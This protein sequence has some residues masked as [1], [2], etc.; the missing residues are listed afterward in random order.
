MIENVVFAMHR[1]SRLTTA[2]YAV[3]RRPPEVRPARDF[4][5]ADQAT[6]HLSGEQ[7]IIRIDRPQQYEEQAGASLYRRS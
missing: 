1:L 3:L 5:P 7:E 2:D 4:M 6:R